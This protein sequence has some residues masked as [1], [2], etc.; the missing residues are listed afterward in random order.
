MER[1]LSDVGTSP[2]HDSDT[3]HGLVARLTTTTVRVHT[4]KSVGRRI[5][6]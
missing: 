1:Y 5:I 4:I 2:P 6:F 3:P